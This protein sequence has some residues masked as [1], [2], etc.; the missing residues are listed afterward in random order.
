MTRRLAIALVLCLASL[1]SAGVITARQ[2]ASAPPVAGAEFL[3]RFQGPIQEP[4]KSAVTAAGASLIEYVPPFAFRARLRPED[5][6]A[7]RGLPFV[8]GVTPYDAGTKVT[9]ARGRASEELFVVRID[10]DRDAAA[11]ASALDGSGVRASRSG[12]SLLVIAA[13]FDQ[14][15]AVAATPGVASIEPFALRVK[16]NEHGGGVILGSRTANANGYDGSS[17]IVGVADTGLG[18]GSAASGHVDIAPARIRALFNRPGAPDSCFDSIADDGAAD[19]DSGHGTHVATAVLGAGNANGV[20]R[21]TAPAAAL[22]FQ[23]LENYA[24][25]SLVCSLLVR[26]LGGLL[27]RGTAWR[28]RRTLPAGLR[29]GG[30]H[31]LRLVGQRGQRRL[32]RR[33]R[34][35]RCIRV[36]APRH[37]AALL[38]RQRRRGCG[39]RRPGRCGLGWLAVYRQER[40]LGG[41]KR[42]R[43]AQRLDLRPCSLVQPVRRARRQNSLFTYGGAWPD[44]FPANPL[45]DD[46]SAGNAE[47][48]AAF[49]SRGPT[50]DGRIKPDVVAPGTWT[51]SGYS[52]LYQQQYDPA[53][54][55]RN[56]QYQYDGWGVPADATHKYMGGTSMAAPLAAGGAAVVRDFYLKARGHQASAAL[57][58]ATLVNTAVDLLD[59]NNDG[60][61][62][63]AYPIPNIHEGWGRV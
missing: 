20:G 47:Q 45:R 24:V 1:M 19:V 21:G 55:A 37:D 60:A 25:P 62:D 49:S 22:V 35:H 57:V 33:C 11:V 5:A 58:K 15:R 48:M 36:G 18:A 27:P 29:P 63:N 14:L 10:R 12:R 54:N 56:G 40:A 53:P 7:L 61:L 8:T 59:E 23:A 26:R 39:R 43:P 46:V 6:G 4:W 44:A 32:H 41:R 34:E 17:Q 3:V 42:E 13:Q 16:H 30:A 50:A 2:P 52:D 28:S 9:K 51:L 31:P 38:G